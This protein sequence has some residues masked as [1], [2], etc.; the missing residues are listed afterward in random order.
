MLIIG[1]GTAYFTKPSFTTTQVSIATIAKTQDAYLLRCVVTNHV[2]EGLYYTNSYTGYPT[3]STYTYLKSNFTT[4][5]SVQEIP[6][7]TTSTSITV[8]FSGTTTG[9]PITE[10]DSTVCTWLPG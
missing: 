8:N 6:G 3:T 10:W 9:P 5:T 4:V 7:Y 2:E 1:F